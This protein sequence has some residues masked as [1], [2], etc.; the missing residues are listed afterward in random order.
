MSQDSMTDAIIQLPTRPEMQALSDGK[1]RLNITIDGRAVQVPEGTLLLDAMRE[2]G[3]EVPAMCYHYTFSSFGSCGICLV[4]VEGKN[5]NVRSCTAK[6]T[7]KMVVRTNTEKMADA[8]KKA[9]EK[10]LTTHPL[11]C[12]VCDA[13]GKCELQ[14]MA[15]SL[16]VYDIK[17][18][19]RKNIPEDTRSVALDFN[20]ER[21]ILCGQCINVCKEVQEIDALCFYKK[22][23]KTH[24]GAHGGV[25]LDCEF[26]GDCLAVCPVG[27]IVSRFSKYAFKPWQLKKTE[28]TCTFCS[29]GCAMT[30][31]S[32][33]PRITRVTSKLSY[34]S[35]WGGEME[36]GDGHGGLCVRGRFGFQFV[37]SD[38]RLSKPLAKI[39]KDDDRQVEI[40]WFKAM[41]LAA[42]RLSEI[43]AQH[44]GGAIAGLISGRCT[45][46]EVYLF[47]RL[48]RGVLGTNH[49]DTAARYGHMNSVRAMQETLGVGWSTTSYKKITLADVIFII[50]SDLTE[51][52]PVASLRVKEAKN[53]FKAKV[54]VADSVRT[55]MQAL[56]THP[57]SLGVSAVATAALA[58]GLI[59]AVVQNGWVHPSFAQKYPDALAAFVQST[60]ALSE[61]AVSQACGV[62]W[63]KI[64]EAAQLLAQSQRGTIL[65]GEGITQVSGGYQNVLRLIDLA[66]LTGLLEK[67]GGGLHPICEENN[68]Q[69]AVDM[70]GVAEFL[71]GQ[72]SAASFSQRSRFGAAW[73][74]TLP[75]GRGLTL[76]EMIAQAVEGKIKAL[77]VVGE[78][79]LGTL[80]AT[81][82]VREALAKIDFVIC[83][84]PFLTETGRAADLVLPAVPFAEKEGTFTNAEGK[85]RPVNR[86]FDPK[87]E[88]RPDW[89]IFSE[90][91]KHLG[92]PLAYRSPEEIREE[93]GPLVPGYFAGARPAIH[94]RTRYMDADFCDG[95][96]GRYCLDDVAPPDAAYPT[97]LRLNQVIYHSGKLSTQDSALMKIYSQPTLSISTADAAALDVKADDSVRLVS[98]LGE[99]VR[100]VEISDAIP[101]GLAL[102][103]EHFAQPEVRDLLPVAV[104]PV[105]HVPYFKWGAVTLSKVV[106]DGLAVLASHTGDEAGAEIQEA[107]L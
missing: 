92:Q 105:T 38:A 36:P 95:I 59:K 64:A 72:V 100:V 15:Y 91:A 70:G 32:E 19:V 20:M 51:T 40:P 77:W 82:G 74:T 14:D 44:G 102:F 71:P 30:L 27:A 18:A 34:F 78:N 54:I 39:A 26:C 88:A 25:P 56:C 61:E 96:A 33:G 29:D 17:K 46:E 48:M 8:R 93:I 22:D 6:I 23:G 68:E 9:V 21:C 28:T 49:I 79:P 69:G 3:M 75:E 13:D 41:P 67:E 10:H 42:R 62:S 58:M 45:N 80:P 98:P 16:G 50:G 31:E 86:A 101:S 7:D 94:E 84:D 24:V 12:P 2:I 65:W 83:Q 87:G 99:A 90:M 81:M 37:Q 106:C 66:M 52:H 35:K 63:E 5:N 89:K 47:G 1:K 73:G 107:V 43:R 4:E 60:A 103:P 104:D 85:I 76:P 57:L 11:D 53:K 55:N 97:T